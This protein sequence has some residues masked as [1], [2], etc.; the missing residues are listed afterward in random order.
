MF[1]IE[2]TEPPTP[3]QMVSVGVQYSPIR[4]RNVGVGT[5]ASKYRD[6][7]IQTSPLPISCEI[8]HE[9]DES[10]DNFDSFS[11]LSDLDCR[12]SS[13]SDP[14]HD[15]DMLEDLDDNNQKLC[16]KAENQTENTMYDEDKSNVSLSPIA[17]KIYVN[18]TFHSPNSLRIHLNT[19]NNSTKN[20]IP[21]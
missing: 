14:L 11:D 21:K 15:F 16:T 20:E 9:T 10:G 7:G 6:F 4:R 8:I 12:G 13:S 3:V 19:N 17:H 5:E 2:P 18:E 1:L